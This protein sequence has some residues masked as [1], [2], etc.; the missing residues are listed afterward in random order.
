MVSFLKVDGSSKF[1]FLSISRNT[2]M[3][4]RVSKKGIIFP[5]HSTDATHPEQNKIAMGKIK[6][7]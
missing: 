3:L 2:A 1:S 7:D 5:V 6:I 4:K